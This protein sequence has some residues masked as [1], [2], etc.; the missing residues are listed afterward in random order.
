MVRHVRLT[1]WSFVTPPRLGKVKVA[2]PCLAT[3]FAVGELFDILKCLSKRRSTLQLIYNWILQCNRREPWRQ[4]NGL[5]LH[6]M[7][8]LG[9]WQLSAL[10]NP[11]N[12]ALA[13]VQRPRPAIDAVSRPL[14]AFGPN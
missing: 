7:Q 10:V 8:P 4:C 3:F 1:C 13:P 9:L 6:L 12:A 14:A 5:A 2:L 11:V